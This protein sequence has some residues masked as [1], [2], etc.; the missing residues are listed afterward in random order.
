MHK[1]NINFKN[2]ICIIW[3]LSVIVTML[4][5]VSCGEAESGAGGNNNADNQAN[6]GLPGEAEDSER[7]NNQANFVND[8]LGHFDFNGYIFRV[9]AREDWRLDAEEQDGEILNDAIYRRNRNVEER[10]NFKFREILFDTYDVAPV[11]RTALLAGDNSYDIMLI[12]GP[13]AYEYASQGMLRPMTDLNYVD[14]DKPYWDSWLTDQFT[15]ANKIFFAAGDYDIQNYGAAAM[16]FNK[17][18]ARDLGIPDI[19]STVRDGE[20]TFE[21]FREYGKAA[22]RDLNGDGRIAAEDQHAYLGVTRNIQPSFWIAGGAKS[23]S[24]DEDNMPYLSAL[25]ERFINVWFKMVD[26]LVTDSVWFHDVADPNELT[27]ERVDLWN[28]TFRDGRSLFIGGG[29]GSAK[30]FRDM[31]I[32]FGIIPYPK[33]DERQE[34][35]Y[36]QLAW[37]EPVSLPAYTTDD[38]MDRTGVILEALACESYNLVTP[39]YIEI[40]LNTKY[41]RDDESEEMLGIIFANRVFDWGDTI[42]TPLL[43]DGIFPHIF[44]SDSDTIV[45]RLE[46]AERNINREID[47]M[48]DAFMNLD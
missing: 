30:D 10:F 7:E 5:A 20:W 36:S 44:V 3:V 38:D 14:F 21:K 43:R 39:V 45:S 26:I 11:T 19:Y 24:F 32:D 25:D 12:R 29:V 23:I 48:V 18:I 37:I 35:Y 42:W 28:N 16:L 6:N 13:T 34:D 31:E 27:H 22:I 4:F 8:D 40:V 41:T 2:I 1:F 9:L 15:I 46:R 33:Y 17:N 47:K